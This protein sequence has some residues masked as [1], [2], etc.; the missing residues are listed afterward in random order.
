[1]VSRKQAKANDK[2]MQKIL[3]FKLTT[4]FPLSLAGDQH[5]DMTVFQRWGIW[6]NWNPKSSSATW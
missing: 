5:W 1:M 6:R 2:N 3:G 4:W